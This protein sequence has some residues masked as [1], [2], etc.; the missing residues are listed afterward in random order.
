[1]RS[2]GIIGTPYVGTRWPCRTVGMRM[3]DGDNFFSG[4]SEI[5][6]GIYQ[7]CRIHFEFGCA[8]SDIRHRNEAATRY[9]S[10]SFPGVLGFGV[11][12]DFFENSGDKDEAHG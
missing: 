7:L 10:T 6:E 5:P 1:M 12:A 3:V 9:E 8:L 11:L 2:V 4:V